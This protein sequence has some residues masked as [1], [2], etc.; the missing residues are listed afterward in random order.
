MV[1]LFRLLILCATALFCTAAVA[2]DE[3]D[4]WYSAEVLN[5]GLG[6]VPDDLDRSTPRAA[7]RAFIA[8]AGANRFTV[9]AH[10]LN[11]SGID[12]ERQPDRAARVAQH[13]YQVIDRRVWV[14]WSD[15]PARPDAKVEPSAGEGNAPGEVRRDLGIKLFE[16]NG[17][18]YEIRIAR[19]K[20]GEDTEPVWLFTPQTVEDVAALHDAYGPRAFEQYIPDPMKEQLGGLRIWEWIGLPIM[21]GL[22]IGIGWS[23]NAIITA[24]SRK[25]PYRFLQHAF[26]RAGFPLALFAVAVLAQGVLSLAVS[27]SGPVTSVVQPLLVIMMAWGVGVAALRIVDA[28]LDRVTLRYVGDIDDTRS[29]DQR[30]LYTSIYA[31]RRIIVLLMVGFAAA[32]VLSQLNLFESIGMTL[33]ASAGVLTVLL[34]IAGQAVLGNILASLQI[35]LAKPVR[36]GDSVLFE[37]DWAYVESIFYTFMRLRT[38]DERRIIVPVRYFVSK[39]FENWSVKDARIMHTV[40]LRLDHSADSDVLRDRFQELAR[41]DEGVIEHDQISCYV[42]GHTVQGMELS[43]YAMSP[44]PSTGWVTQMRLR[45]GLLR[46][47]RERHPE[48]WPQERIAGGT[49]DVAAGDQAVRSTDA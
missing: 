48:W 20:S 4:A 14:D 17:R 24:L 32:Y 42:T 25:A 9:A 39:P 31:L 21:L 18:A 23:V 5:E 36:I 45:E 34:G 7:M 22:L 11:L 6:P 10:V 38:W 27:F 12:P 13:L 49:A 44:D 28:I 29:L 16:L 41:E 35:A 46:F 30:E 19:Y 43:F 33:L 47:I 8:N 1:S 15:L 37:G 40:R 3:S 2:Q 26:A